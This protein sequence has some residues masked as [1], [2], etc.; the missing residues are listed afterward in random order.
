MSEPTATGEV[1]DESTPTCEAPPRGSRLRTWGS[2]IVVAMLVLLVLHIVGV[3]RPLEQAVGAR[4]PARPADALGAIVDVFSCCILSWKALTVMLPAFLLAAAISTFVPPTLILKYLGAGANRF[5]AY[6]VAAVAGFGLP[7]CSC[8]VVPLFLSIYRRGAGIGP[9]FTFLF[10]GPSI[11]SVALIFTFQVI[12]WRLGIWRTLAVPLIG[13]AVGLIMAALFRRED[14]ERRAAAPATRGVAMAA[15]PRGHGRV[16]VL[17]GL[18]T[19]MVPVGAWEM[20]WQYRLAG[21]AA[22]V[23]AVVVLLTRRFDRDE[24]ATWGHETWTLVR[25]IIPVLL[26]AILVIGA[27]AAYIDVKLVYRLVGAVPDGSSFLRQV[28]PIG[29]A[30]AFGA[31][32]YFPELAEVAFA[33]AFLK[34]GMDV[35]PALAILLTGAGMSLP[36]V[37]LITRGVGWRKAVAYEVVVIVLCI[38]FAYLFSS[39][40]GQYICQC[41]MGG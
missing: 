17:L 15:D 35:G 2:A 28:Q 34:L 12:G 19:A 29:L 36:G 3:L 25:M 41:M 10:A 18:L 13:I 22:L 21:L 9:A 39:Q 4:L 5:T 38:A 1:P 20:P 26:P 27:V 24:V 16:W 11:S 31:L 30:A 14:Q 8:N 7:L 32:T 40:I 33:K 37:I 6:A 23:V